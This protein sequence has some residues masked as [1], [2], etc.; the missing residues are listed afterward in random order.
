MEKQLLSQQENIKKFSQLLDEN[1]MNDQKKEFEYLIQYIDQMENQFDTVLEELRSVK[2][3]LNTIQDKT[4]RATANKVVD[5][6]TAKVTETKKTLIKLKQHVIKTV[7]KAVNEFK[8]QGKSALSS[9]VKKLNVKEMIKTIKKGLDSA[10]KLMDQNIDYLSKL[11][12]EIHKANSHLKNVGRIFIGKDTKEITPRNTE[13][14]LISKTQEN[15]FFC[16]SVFTKMSV[17]TD[18]VLNTLSELEKNEQPKKSVKSELNDI[19]KTNNRTANTKVNS[20]NEIHLG[21]R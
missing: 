4:F 12:D 6:V 15:L 7:D 13:K 2:Q 8:K 5:K 19:K 17:K 3:E 11:G 18:V 10:T 1:G 21:Q 20:K 16:M 14:G 9:A